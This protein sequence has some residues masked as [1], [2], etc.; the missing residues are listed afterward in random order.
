MIQLFGVFISLD[1][2][3]FCENVAKYHYAHLSVHL[4]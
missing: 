4:L 3:G 1:L 2:L